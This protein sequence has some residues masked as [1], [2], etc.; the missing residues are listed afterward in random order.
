MHPPSANDKTMED[1]LLNCLQTIES[2]FTNSS[3]IIAG[4]FNRLNI[5][6]ICRHFNLKQIVKFPT[7]NN[8]TLDYIITNLSNYYSPPVRCAHLASPTITCTI[9][10]RRHSH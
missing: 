9:S 1:Y 6:N 7:R 10:L 3:I 8:V 2:K 5:S 4:D